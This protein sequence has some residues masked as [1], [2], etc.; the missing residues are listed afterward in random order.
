VL[1]LTVNGIAPLASVRSLAESAVTSAGYA[2]L[3]GIMALETVF[4]PIPS[5]IVLPLAGFEVS[6][7][8]LSFV[9]ALVAA[10]VG[11]LAGSLALYCLARL[12]GR[13]TV[14]R[15]GR[16]LRVSDADLDRADRWFAKRGTALVFFGRMV[17]G[18]RSLVS[19]PAGFAAMPVWRFALV[20]AAGSAVWNAALLTAGTLLGNNYRQVDRYL[21]PIATALVAV[22]LLAAIAIGVRRYRARLRR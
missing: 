22:L 5:E 8:R 16:V 7:G 17:P 4:P 9:A 11:A 12:G 18:A 6:Q 3:V 2:G 19:I 15:F 21:G 13:S 14:A 10:T 20:T 1:P